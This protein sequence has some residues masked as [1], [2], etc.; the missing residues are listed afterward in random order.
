MR[1]RNISP[2]IFLDNGGAHL[3]WK[4][5]KQIL[6][7]LSEHMQ[8]TSF[9]NVVIDI[10][11]LTFLELTYIIALVSNLYLVF[12]SC[13]DLFAADYKSEWAHESRKHLKFI[14]K[15]LFNVSRKRS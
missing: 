14:Y 10:N 11:F 15:L 3:G 1:L 5:L 6:H 8:H 4:P 2:I 7:K 12:L 9:I 13:C